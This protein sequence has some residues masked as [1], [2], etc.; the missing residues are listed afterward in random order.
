VGLATCAILAA[1][2]EP[3]TMLAGAAVLAAGLAVRALGRALAPRA[4]AG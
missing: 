3:R 4:G 1:S 2:L